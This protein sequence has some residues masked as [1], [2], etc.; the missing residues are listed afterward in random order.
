LLDALLDAL[1]AVR[2]TH[3]A[4]SILVAGAALFS[5]LVAEPVWQRPDPLSDAWLQPC[6][7]HIA[8]VVG[9]GLA[10]AVTSGA[11]QLVLI[12]AAATEETWTDVIGDGTAWT[13]LLETHFGA[14]AQLRLLLALV[15]AGLLLQSTRARA[16]PPGWLR[17][18]S[19]AVA[20]AF[21]GSLAWTGHA[22]SAT[23]VGA[24]THLL[25]D[26]VHTLA[27]GAWVGGLLPL[28]L[29]MRLVTYA[30]ADNRS[31]EACGR[32][33]RRFSTLGV[34]SV[35]ALV[36]SGLVNTWYLT[37]HMR[38][39]FG[40]DYGWFVQIKVGLFL[41]MLCLAAVNRLRLVPVASQAEGPDAQQRRMQALRRL[42]ITTA[43][44]IAL[45]LLVIYIV[46]VLGMTPPAGHN[47]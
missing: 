34:A 9:L 22:A 47:H 33:L 30:A 45:G 27:A 19:A 5:V 37:N 7:R 2:A 16:A 28:A 20:V 21:L 10:L 39:L 8:Q 46:G 11:V 29:F 4:A 43:G 17:T 23:G 3:F 42:R 24:N 13:F 41:A 40:T 26:L 12:A 38:E 14:I 15:L 44:E 25:N 18:L 35:S 6:R 32:V 36:A 31:L 1:I